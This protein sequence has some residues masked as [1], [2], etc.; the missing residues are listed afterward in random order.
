MTLKGDAKLKEKMTCSFKYDLRDLVN[1][2][3][4]TL[5]CEISF[6]MV[7]FSPKYTL[8]E[9]RKYRGVIFHDIEQWYKIWINPDIVV[10]KMAW[11]IGWAF[12]RALKYLKNCTLTRSFCPMYIMFQPENF[13]GIMCCDIAGWWKI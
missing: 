8:L 10:S 5:K 12:I 2:H 9:L 11:G 13:V 3:P 4:T 7:S 1:F 6:S